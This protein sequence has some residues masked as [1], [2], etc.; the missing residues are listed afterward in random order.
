MQNICAFYFI[1]YANF[2]TF[3]YLNNYVSRLKTFILFFVLF[4]LYKQRRRMPNNIYI[5]IEFNSII[6]KIFANISETNK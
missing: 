3:T 2:K 5:W 4:S 6:L 1:Y